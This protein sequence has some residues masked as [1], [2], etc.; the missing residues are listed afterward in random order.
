[1]ERNI[2]I[3]ICLSVLHTFSSADKR[4]IDD[5]DGVVDAEKKDL[6]YVTIF[7]HSILNVNFSVTIISNTNDVCKLGCDRIIIAQVNTTKGLT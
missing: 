3:N 2:Y 1:M 4:S 6:L 5:V 7:L